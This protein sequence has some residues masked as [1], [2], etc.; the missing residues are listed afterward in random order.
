L[1]V[2]DPVGNHGPAIERQARVAA[3]PPGSDDAVMLN[4]LFTARFGLWR[5]L[6]PH[7]EGGAR[8]LPM[9]GEEGEVRVLDGGLPDAEP[10]SG[11]AVRLARPQGVGFALTCGAAAPC[12]TR[13]LQRLLLNTPPER[14]A[15]VIPSLPP[16]GD[17][18]VLD[19][20]LAQPATRGRVS[21]LIG[22]KGLAAR[23]YRAAIDLGLMGPVPG[24]TP[25]HAVPPPARG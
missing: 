21:A 10:G 14:D 12:D 17:A 3:P 4:A 8:L 11:V 13:V 22:T 9:A 1:G 19:R 16:P 25:D 5:V 15:P 20:L 6:G 7:P 23:A 24:R 2:F 18:A